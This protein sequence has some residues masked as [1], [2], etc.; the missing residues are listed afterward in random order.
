M[1][2]PVN[3]TSSDIS[4]IEKYCQSLNYDAEFSFLL[5]VSCSVLNGVA[6]LLNDLL[7]QVR[8]YNF[9]FIIEIH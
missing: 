6:D 9:C 7:N 2:M 4:K 3:K 1:I 5:D 8:N